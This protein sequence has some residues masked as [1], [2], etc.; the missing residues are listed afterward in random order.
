[1]GTA[2]IIPLILALTVAFMGYWV[3]IPKTKR[4]FS[5]Q[6]MEAREESGALK[7]STAIGAELYTLLPEAFDRIE[8]KES[9]PRIQSLLVGSGNPWGL[10]ANEFVFFQYVCA[11]IGFIVG[12]GVHLI[13]ALYTGIPWFITVPA[14]TAFA[15]FIPKITYSEQARKRDMEFKRQLPEALGLLE[16][17]V[18]GGTP[19]DM[20]L[21]SVVPH[22]QEGVLKEEFISM[23]NSLDSG[24]SLKETLDRF[25]DRAPNE[26]IRTFV[27]ALQAANE[28][29]TPLAEI[30]SARAEASRAEFF[31]FLHGK[32]AQ[33]E[34]KLGM[35]LA[36]TLLPAVLIIVVAPSLVQLGNI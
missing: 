12:W 19:F 15:F 4:S 11:F 9:L 13:L 32:V 30:L 8:R 27:R 33:L 31:T 25:A 16:I 23:S 6:N 5:P 1:M 2:Y 7:I 14:V 24:I 3:F 22:L 36:P 18:K 20:A 17:S 35:V 34:S 28:V 10:K 21:R 26:G 29:N